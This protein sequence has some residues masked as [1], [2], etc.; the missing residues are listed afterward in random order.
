MRRILILSG[1]FVLFIGYFF[2]ASPLWSA[3]PTDTIFNPFT[4]KQDFVN[5]FDSY[6]STPTFYS[7]QVTSS[8]VLN[9]T[10][11]F[12]FGD[13]VLSATQ[14]WTGQ[15]TFESL[16]T[17]S[18]SISGVTDL[19]WAD[20]TVQVSSPPVQAQ[21]SLGITI[22]GAGSAIT[23]GVKGY[24]SVPYD[25]TVQSW[26]LLA[27]QSGSIV[28]DVWKDTFGNHPPTVADT[29][30][31][32]DKPTLA[33]VALSSSSALTGWTTGVSEG[34]VIGFNVDSVATVTQVHLSIVVNKQ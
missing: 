30:A 16:V 3:P 17:I 2:M 8:V 33:S 32:S 11:Y 12:S 6:S 34:D 27:D 13:A 29:I 7:I 14:T 10:T 22:D 18:T 5:Y 24:V 15:N 4:G 9:G 28:I 20:G 19:T 26:T 23:T 25:A 1:L 21:G 31:G